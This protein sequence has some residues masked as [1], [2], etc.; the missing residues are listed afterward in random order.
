MF[1]KL[2]QGILGFSIL[3]IAAAPVQAQRP[4]V[5]KFVLDDTI[6]PVTAGQLDRALSRANSDGAAALLIELDTPGGLVD[7]MR[8]MA[9]AILS[10]RVPVIIYVAPAGARAGSAGFFLLEAADVAAMAPGTN[11]GAAHVVFEFGK[12][13]QTM[14]QKV[15]ND[16]EAFL[17]SYVGRRN[18]NVDAAI[19]AVQSSHAYSAEEALQ[20]HLIDLTASSDT[21]LLEQL[22]GREI[23]R[24]DGSKQV[25]HLANARIETLKPTLREDLLGWLVDPNIA[26]LLLVAGALLIYLEF[27]TP[28]TIVPGALGTLMVLMAI[29]GLNLLPIRYTAVM[30]LLAALV[31][32]VLEAKFGGHGALAIAGIVCLTLG[33]LT[34]IAAPVPELAVNPWVAIGISAGFGGITVFLVRLAVRARRAKQMLGLDALVGRAASAME[35][36]APEGHVLVEGEIWRAFADQPVPAGTPL[37]VTGRDEYRLHVT[38]AGGEVP[39]PRTED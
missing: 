24:L 12:P 38:P 37:R 39:L 1:A 22:N 19:A 27:N 14:E 28:G 30:L 7:S 6:Q 29:F 3:L 18:R 20:Q 13:D 10:S 16:A 34:L 8:R 23:T 15:E 21:Q 26:L 17:R 36:L 33:T 5:D 11:A 32:L 35:P 31:L 2:A 4:L 9:G 25:L